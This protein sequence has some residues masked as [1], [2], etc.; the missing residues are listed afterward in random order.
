M[1]LYVLCFPFCHTATQ[2]LAI[3][4]GPGRVLVAIC[5][6]M[7][8]ISGI[9]R[10]LP[11]WHYHLGLCHL[12]RCLP[13]TDCRLVTPRCE[14][15]A[16][17]SPYSASFFQVYCLLGYTRSLF[18]RTTAQCGVSLRERLLWRLYYYLRDFAA[19][20]LLLEINMQCKASLPRTPRMRQPVCDH[21]ND[22]KDPAYCSPCIHRDRIAHRKPFIL[23]RRNP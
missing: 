4:L 14:M 9:Y 10:V 5:L 20:C 23:S 3:A 2:L 8:S 15:D 11:H 16:R 12:V 7:A 22:L 6:L 1:A 17:V 19:P 18:P 13:Q 21:L